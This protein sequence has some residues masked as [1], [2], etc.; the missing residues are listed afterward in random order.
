MWHWEAYQFIRV[1][2][3]AESIILSSLFGG[4]M[5]SVFVCLDI[6]ISIHF[7][8]SLS[9]FTIEALV[10]SFVLVSYVIRDFLS[11]FIFNT[12][13]CIQRIYIYLLYLLGWKSFFLWLFIF[14]TSKLRNDVYACFIY[15]GRSSLFS[16][17]YGSDLTYTSYLVMVGDCS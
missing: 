4:R 16:T 13:G 14:R 15:C 11:Y 7:V 5:L 10:F 3:R 9:M 6:D 12:H 1:G 2:H 17:R 8:L